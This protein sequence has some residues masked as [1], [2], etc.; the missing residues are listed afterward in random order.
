MKKLACAIA[1]AGLIGTPAFAADMAVK[2]APA[3]PAPVFSW[4]GFYL[5]VELGAKWADTTWTTTSIFSGGS[6]PVD[7]SSPRNYEPSGFRWGGY[8]GY[9]WQVLPQWLWGVEADWA[10][11]NNTV[12]AAGVPGCT[13]GCPPFPGEGH[14]DTSSVKMDW[15]ASVRARL[16]YLVTPDLLAYATGGMTWQRVTASATCQ[17]S[18]DDPLCFSLAGNPFAT[19]TNSAILTG[20]TIG[21]GIE[22]RIYGNWLLRGEYRYSNFGTWSGDRLDLSL[23]S[24]PLLLG[25]SLKVNTQIATGGIGYKF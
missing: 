23:P 22:Y 11:A 20:W 21:G 12:T 2:A 3:A 4:T 15:D 18:G 16:G 7:A 19:G 6:F 14:A 17:H 13:I 9:N 5:G 25:H 8:V 24:S 1:V 10:G